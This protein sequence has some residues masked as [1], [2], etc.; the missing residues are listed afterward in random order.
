MVSCV[1]GEINFS[2]LFLMCAF[3]SPAWARQADAQAVGVAG[4]IWLIIA[5]Y[6]YC[7]TKGLSVRNLKFPSDAWHRLGDQ[8]IIVWAKI[9]LAERGLLYD[10][11][12]L[13]RDPDQVSKRLVDRAHDVDFDEA[14]EKDS[15]DD[16][17]DDVDDD[18]DGDSND[19]LSSDLG[20]VDPDR[21]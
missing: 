15:G 13:G 6:V 5:A 17:D 14:L 16:L 19:E 21:R 9:W 8:W 1:S 18:A 11:A 10:P 20:G 3:T 7:T 2:L 12:T 4:S